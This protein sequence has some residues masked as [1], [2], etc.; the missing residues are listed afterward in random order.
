MVYGSRHR[1]FGYYSVEY[2]A[3]K[4]GIAML[5]NFIYAKN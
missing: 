3:L 1:N 4:S 5:T 2:T